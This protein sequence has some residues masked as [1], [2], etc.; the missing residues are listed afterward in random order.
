MID[1]TGKLLI[2]IRSDATVAA[3]TTRVRAGE[4]AQGDAPPFVVI[5]RFPITPFRRAWFVPVAHYQYLIQCYGTTPQQAAQLAGAVMD[6]VS[7]SAPRVNASGV[8]IY[9]SYWNIGGQAQRD[10]DTSWP[11][12]TVIATVNAATMV[13]PV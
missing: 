11:F 8:A 9:N 3:I 10:P 12:E 6:V 2:E 7:N 5:R 1:P 4:A 13:A